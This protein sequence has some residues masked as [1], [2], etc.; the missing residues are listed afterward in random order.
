MCLL[1]L[2][3]VQKYWSINNIVLDLFFQYLD[4]S[5]VRRL[6]GGQTEA[7]RDQTNTDGSTFVETA[8]ATT[9]DAN[10]PATSMQTQPE[11][12]ESD[13]YLNFFST[14]WEGMDNS[15]LDFGLLFDPVQ[16]SAGTV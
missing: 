16:R 6:H 11:A 10:L 7:T 4:K 12:L 14:S 2:K 8:S 5:T 15:T 9:T 3:E 1:G 13:L